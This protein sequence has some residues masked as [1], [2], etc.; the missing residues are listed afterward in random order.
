MQI[1]FSHPCDSSV[2][3]IFLRPRFNRFTLG[4]GE[5]LVSRVTNI[6]REIM[7]YV[8]Y[9]SIGSRAFDQRDVHSSRSG[10]S[11]TGRRLLHRLR[12]DPL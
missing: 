7:E 10:M 1:L 2:A 3:G 8:A 4:R 6:P 11:I 12:V 5:Y 9:L